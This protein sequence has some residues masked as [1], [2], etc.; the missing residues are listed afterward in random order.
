[1]TEQNTQLVPEENTASQRHWLYGFNAAV[2]VIVGLVA[3]IFIFAVTE[4]EQVKQHTQ[5]DWSSN[6][7]NSLSS[8]SKA[9]LREIDKKNQK[10]QIWSL[11]TDATDELKRNKPEDAKKQDQQ[12]V[13]INDL[14]HQY[15]RASSNITI[16]DRGDAARD[17]IE[18][19]IRDKYKDE[20]KPYSDA[21]D[22]VQPLQT[23]L[24]K[25][26]EEEGAS[27]G[28]FAQKP[29]TP[30]EEVRMLGSL[31]NQFAKAPE[32][33]EEMNHDIRRKVEGATLPNYGAI[34]DDIVQNLGDID[35]MFTLLSDPAKVK[36]AGFPPSM[37]AYF[38]E[39]N[40]KY[41]AMA[42][43]LKNY[44]DDLN[45]LPAL[46]VQDV[47]SG[48][49]RNTLVIL[50]EKTAKVILPYDLFSE[51]PSN[52]NS[53]SQG[54]LTFN[55]EQAISSALYAIANPDK[56]KV[57]FVTASPQH[58]L[59]S[60]YAGMK[61]TLE[62]NNFEVLEWAP[63]SGDPQAA[64]SDPNPPAIGRGVVWIVFTPDPPNMQMM[65]MAPPNPG[66]V[67]AAAKRH[68][69]EGGQ[70]L[71]MAEAAMSFMGPPGFPYDELV[72]DYG[73]DVQAKY[74]VMHM[75]ST[76]DDSGNTLQRPIPYSEVSRFPDTQITAPMQSLPSLFGPLQ[77]QQ[78]VM[79]LS[80][81]VQLKNPMPSGAEG[82]VFATTDYSA[83]YWGESELMGPL[84]SSKFDKDADYA[85]PPGGIP[86][87]AYAIRNKGQ[88]DKEQRVAVIGSKF[89]GSNFFT[90]D[91]SQP[92]RIGSNIYSVPR[93]PGNEE[94]MKNT[95]L[96]LAGYE[97]MISV[98]SKANTASRIG[99]VKPGLLNF[100]RIAVVALIPLLAMGLGM[101]VWGIRRR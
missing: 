2:M 94:L 39:N 53:N 63:P 76:S 100:I 74:A 16:E 54:E 50:G 15:S 92:V 101:A 43:E 59:D 21:V 65:M 36:A 20:L 4:A 58:L 51:A 29:G 99:D 27:I 31:Q 38:T 41:K 85:C 45:K 88:K 78:G 8:G 56:V 72:K 82:K 95:V 52:P 10:F 71:F 26:L 22:K 69:E 57:V 55:G 32:A 46:K 3:I 84:G 60:M 49:G 91:L 47:L 75:I 40:A 14:L 9:M 24:A 13:Q 33:F 1:M 5:W 97:N 42:T 61:S 28:A 62:Q 68:M 66:P 93:F 6:G 7:A 48:I 79:G 44:L 83:D 37:V 25:F 89:L 19:Q 35:S 70:V 11:F 90:T 77:S 67:I 23:K 17:T 73:I 34:R 86:L 64:P 80:T 87:A 96:W 98:S 81:V 30:A 12:R 18:T